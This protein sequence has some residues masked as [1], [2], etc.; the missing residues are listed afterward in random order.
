MK[1]KKEK[2]ENLSA[3]E[4]WRTIY[5]GGGGDTEQIPNTSN[6]IVCT[7]QQEKKLIQERGKEIS[8]ERMKEYGRGTI[9]VGKN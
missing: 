7:V 5:S 2:K 9:E 1:T 8:N 6:E 4:N 3:R